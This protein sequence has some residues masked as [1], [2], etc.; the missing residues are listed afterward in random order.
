MYSESFL[1]Q[2]KDIKTNIFFAGTT[3]TITTHNA[4][5]RE[6]DNSTYDER[7]YKYVSNRNISNY[8]F[9]G[10]CPDFLLN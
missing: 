8:G 7:L 4:E 2:R 6:L 1:V 5:E 9:A 3:F 10:I